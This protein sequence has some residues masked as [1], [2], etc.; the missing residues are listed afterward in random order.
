MNLTE[1]SL[2]HVLHVGAALALMGYTFYA[3]AA[4]PETRKPVMIWTGTASLVM[5]LTGLRM[6]QIAYAFAPAGWVFVKMA[7]WLGLAALAGIA[8][9]RRWRARVL[10]WVALVLAVTAVTMVYL[11]PF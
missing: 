2:L 3:L 11:R 10:A 4:P 5:L 6:W 1:L 9:R 8:Y 7:C